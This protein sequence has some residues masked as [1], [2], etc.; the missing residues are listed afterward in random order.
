MKTVAIVLSAIL[1]L[2]A[3]A[4]SGNE[5]RQPVSNTSGTSQDPNSPPPTAAGAPLTQ[6]DYPG[7]GSTVGS[8]T[9]KQQNSGYFPYAGAPLTA[10]NTN[11]NR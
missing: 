10:P 11:G 1:A 4:C 6:P 3:A 7:S 8:T 9:E 2:T 5:M